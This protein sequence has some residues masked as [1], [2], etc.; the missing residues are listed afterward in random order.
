MADRDLRKLGRAELIEIIFALQ[1]ENNALAERNKKLQGLL[2][3][4][5]ITLTNAGSIAEASLKLNK[6]FEAAQAAADQYVMSVR[7]AADRAIK[8]NENGTGINEKDTVS[9]TNNILKSLEEIKKNDDIQTENVNKN[10]EKP[11]KTSAKKDRSKKNSTD[12]DRLIGI[13]EGMLEER[14]GDMRGVN[15][16]QDS[17]NSDSDIEFIDLDE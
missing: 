15:V 1:K 4:K 12:A 8:S 9:Q 7:L 3:E 16:K 5:Y 13:F 10:S 17:V 6:V 11:V 2:D 14:N